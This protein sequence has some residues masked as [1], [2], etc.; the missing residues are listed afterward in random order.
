MTSY[1]TQ[2]IAN[3]FNVSTQTIRN[4][5]KKL[6]LK[7]RDNSKGFLFNE[8]QLI[9]IA[10]YL[11]KPTNINEQNNEDSLMQSIV[12]SLQEQLTTKDKQIESLERI[13]ENQQKQIS[14][15]VETNKQLTAANTIQVAADKQEFLLTDVIQEPKKKGW[16]ARLFS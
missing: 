1:T 13:V 3:K 12:N 15:L 10:Q 11:D 14:N 7:P 6:D 4:I 2:N 8:E 5:A 16:L 9:S